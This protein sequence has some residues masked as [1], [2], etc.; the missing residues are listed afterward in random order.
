MFLRMN[1]RLYLLN[2]NSKIYMDFWLLNVLVFFNGMIFFQYFYLGG[3]IFM[4]ER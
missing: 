1:Y 2:K 3:C 4:M